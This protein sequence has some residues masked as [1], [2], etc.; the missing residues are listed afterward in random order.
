M[1]QVPQTPITT[2]SD[3]NTVTFKLPDNDI[4]LV[5]W[6]AVIDRLSEALNPIITSLQ[7]E[8]GSLDLIIE[9]I[10]EWLSEQEGE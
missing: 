6:K 7:A 1:S 10:D 4:T 3:F 9:R 5:S 2:N 8:N